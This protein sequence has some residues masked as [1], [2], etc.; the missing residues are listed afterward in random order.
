MTEC[1]QL[2]NYSYSKVSATI[3]KIDRVPSL[4]WRTGPSKRPNLH[5]VFYEAPAGKAKQDRHVPQGIRDHLAVYRRRTQLQNSTKGI[6]A[7][8]QQQRWS[9]IPSSTNPLRYTAFAQKSTIVLA[10]AS[11]DVSPFFRSDVAPP[12]GERPSDYARSR[13][14]E[15]L[16]L[17]ECRDRHLIARKECD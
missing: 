5:L 15:D 9:S 2:F 6:D 8:A 1:K 14:S 17:S 4:F 16:H 10:K 11:L 12:R 3:C 7:L 13:L